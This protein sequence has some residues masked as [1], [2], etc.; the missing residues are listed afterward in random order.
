MRRRARTRLVDGGRREV[1]GVLV[2]V[3]RRHME[4]EGRHQ[5]MEDHRQD[6]VRHHQDTARRHQVTAHHQVHMDQW[7]AKVDQ[8]LDTLH[9]VDHLQEEATD[10]HLVD[11]VLRLQGM[12]R[13][14][15]AMVALLLADMEVP[16]VVVTAGRRLAMV[17]HSLL[18][19]REDLLQRVARSCHQAGSS[20]TI[21]HLA[22]H[23]IAIGPQARRNGRHLQG[24]DQHQVLHL[25]LDLDLDLQDQPQALLLVLLLVLAQVL[26]LDQALVLVQLLDPVRDQVCLQAGSRHQILQVVGLTSSTDPRTRQDGSRRHRRLW[27]LINVVP[28][29]APPLHSSSDISLITERK[30]EEPTALG[31][32]GQ[33]DRKSVV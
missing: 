16:L 18:M 31:V 20:T 33:E 3:D 21:Q 4:V 9:M 15:M 5:D 6:M 22:S 1:R 32:P 17:G 2:M 14:R 11:M 19:E 24:Q 27:V 28:P 26:V 25:H 8:I 29:R 30:Y 7:V 12:V 13:R 23:I 10:R